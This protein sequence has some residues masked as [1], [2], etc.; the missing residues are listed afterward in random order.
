MKTLLALALVC[1]LGGTLHAQ[2]NSDESRRAATREKMRTLLSSAGV[3]LGVNF[4]QS[5]RQPFNFVGSLES[6]LQN[7]ESMEILVMIGSR[8]V[9]TIEVYPH[10]R[11]G[12]YINVGRASNGTG[13]MR[14]LLTFNDGGFF[15]WGADDADDVFA[16]F[17]FT[18]ESGFPTESMDIV[19]RSIPLLDAK[20]GELSNLVRE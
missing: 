15:Y 16:A 5:E 12:G 2:K 11:G 9:I 3:K 6:G 7:A 19:L 13:L 10:M 17:N 20:V 14:K 1:T 18:L 4:R 8:D